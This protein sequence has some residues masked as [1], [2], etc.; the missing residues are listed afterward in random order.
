MT[1]SSEDL[2]SQGWAAATL[3]SILA[4][5]LLVLAMIQFAMLRKANADN[6]ALR[7]EVAALEDESAIDDILFGAMATAGGQVLYELNVAIDAGVALELLALRL[8]EDDG[9]TR[10]YWQGDDLFVTAANCEGVDDIAACSLED[11]QVLVFTKQRVDGVMRL[12]PHQIEEHDCEAW[13]DAP[14]DFT[15]GVEEGFDPRA[16]F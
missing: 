2:S 1:T 7:E 5:M 14:D 16:L 8:L 4:G 3:V 10:L 6:D 9:V 11:E 15:A 13:E 12:M